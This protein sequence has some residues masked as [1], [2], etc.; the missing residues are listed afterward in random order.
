MKYKVAIVGAGNLGVRHLQALSQSKY[1][2]EITVFD[3]NNERLGEAEKLYKEVD[4]NKINELRY[5]NDIK[6]IPS[7]IDIVIVATTAHVRR[8]VID[9][10]VENISV[11]YFVLEKYLF[12]YLE[13]YNY[14]QHL[15]DKKKITAWVNCPRRM[16]EYYN[17][18]KKKLINVESFDFTLTGAGWGMGSNIIHFIDIIAYMAD[19]QDIEIDITKLDNNYLE[20]KRDGYKEITG[21]IQGRVGKCSHFSITCLKETVEPML[22]MINSDKIKIVLDEENRKMLVSE[23]EN[24]WRWDQKEI[25]FPFQSHISNIVIDEII[26]N[27]DCGLTEFSESCKLHQVVHLPLSNYFEERGCGKQCPIT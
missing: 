27:G 21:T 22:I 24:A 23:K 9:D 6:S 7:E 12:N 1:E 10:I 15:F 5:V 8:K 17:Y 25:D 19:S 11:K 2:L 14:I 13:D 16:F 4:I 18:I 3:I 26:E 20:S